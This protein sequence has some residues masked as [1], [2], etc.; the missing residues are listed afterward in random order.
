VEQFTS[1]QILSL[2]SLKQISKK[3]GLRIQSILLAIYGGV[4][5]RYLEGSG[6]PVPDFLVQPLPQ[7][8]P[9]RPNFLI[10]NRFNI[11]Y[12]PIPLHRSILERIH[13]IE[14]K[15]H[16]TYANNMYLLYTHVFVR[17]YSVFPFKVLKFLINN[18]TGRSGF[19]PLLFPDEFSYLTRT[20]TLMCPVFGISCSAVGKLIIPVIL[21]FVF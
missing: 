10:G 8:V 13:Y 6:K 1:T 3:H 16:E 19:S 21:H 11:I 9:G 5:R 20:A 4:L 17:L 14:M 7:L 15:V 18:T 2:T 12:V